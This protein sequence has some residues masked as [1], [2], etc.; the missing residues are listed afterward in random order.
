M[1]RSIIILALLV[2]LLSS[3]PAHR[4][5]PVTKMIL[6]KGMK[7]VPSKIEVDIG[8]TVIWKNES[9]G[10]HNVIAND[11]SFKSNMLE[12]GQI[13]ALVFEKKG[14]YKYFCQPHRIMG[15]KGIIEV[16]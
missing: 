8:D 1:F 4:H 9:G 16:K 12:K 5:Q 6:M 3:T 10:H 7:F 14:S 13:Y 11:G 15:M 2:S